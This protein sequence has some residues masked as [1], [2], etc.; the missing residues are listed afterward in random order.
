MVLLHNKAR[1]QSQTQFNLNLIFCSIPNS[2]TLAPCHNWKP[3]YYHQC[4]F[5]N[6]IFSVSSSYPS[7]VIGYLKS[8]AH[9][10]PALMKA[11][12]IC[13]H[14]SYILWDLLIT[15]LKIHFYFP[16]S[17]TNLSSKSS[18]LVFH[19][20][21]YL[22]FHLSHSIIFFSHKVLRHLNNLLFST[23]FLKCFS[24]GDVY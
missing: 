3:W 21:F 16:M 24:K 17:S 7:C 20:L 8:F 11:S 18:W 5:L 6:I 15:P 22:W 9:C 1:H 2:L 14:T 10:F 23:C 19:I 4:N 12:H 13:V